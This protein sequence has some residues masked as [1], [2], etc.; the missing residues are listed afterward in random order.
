MVFVYCVTGLP[1]KSRTATVTSNGTPLI[2]V[3]GTDTPNFE[4]GPA[5]NVTVG[6]VFATGVS[7]DNV[8]VSAF[9]DFSPQVE[10]PAGSVSEHGTYVLVEPV[11]GAENVTVCPEIGLPSASL[12]TIVIAEAAT[13]SAVTGLVPVID[14]FAAIAG[15]ATNVTVGPVFATGVSSDNVFVSAFN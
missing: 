14:E 1:K 2:A 5:T 15:P 4:A 9:N 7:S 11:S 13:P 6:P 12:I 8:F 3:V 10:L